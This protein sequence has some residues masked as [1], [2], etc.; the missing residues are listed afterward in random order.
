VTDF[1]ALRLPDAPI[2]RRKTFVAAAVRGLLVQELP[3]PSDSKAIQELSA[4]ASIV[5]SGKI[6]GDQL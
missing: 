1:P 4:L 6:D 5:F 3:P 2:R